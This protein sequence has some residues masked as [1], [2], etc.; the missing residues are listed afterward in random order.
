MGRILK[1]AMLDHALDRRAFLA[2][3]GTAIASAWLAADPDQ[4]RA[5]LAHAARA[6]AA[7]PAPSWEFLTP[8]QAADVDAIVAQIIPTDDLPGAR[9]AGAVYFVDH[10]LATWAH[11]QRAPFA[12]GLDELNREARFRWPGAGRFVALSSERQIELLHAIEQTPF[13]KSIRFV[14]IAGTFANPSWGG[15]HDKIGWRIL[16][17]E[18]GFVW[19]PPFGDYDAD[20]NPRK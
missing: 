19:Q 16:G 10:S 8:D 13:F 1:P 9:E 7:A 14:T 12:R 4:L 3:S 2:A 20:A 15:N 6:R 11:D 5:S 18:D 17:F